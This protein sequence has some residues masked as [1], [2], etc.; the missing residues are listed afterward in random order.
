MSPLRRA[1]LLFAPNYTHEA[2]KSPYPTGWTEALRRWSVIESVGP[3]R[4]GLACAP[5]FV[6]RSEGAIDR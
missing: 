4:N 6:K 3:M 5:C 2:D 1:V